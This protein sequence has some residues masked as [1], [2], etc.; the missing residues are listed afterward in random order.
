MNSK[1]KQK[2]KQIRK[3]M[4]IELSFVAGGNAKGYSYFG[5]QAV[6]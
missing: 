2:E 3:K 4:N 1:I 6:T 5:R